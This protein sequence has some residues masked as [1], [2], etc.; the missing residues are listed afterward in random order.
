M[1]IEWFSK[2]TFIFRFLTQIETNTPY[3]NPLVT[4]GLSHP[5]HFDE[6]NFIFRGTPPSPPRV[7]FFHFFFSYFDENHVS[8]QKITRLD[9]TICGA[10]LWA[11]LSAYT[12]GAN[13]LKIS[14]ERYYNVYLWRTQTNTTASMRTHTNALKRTFTN[15]NE[16]CWSAYS[17]VN[18]SWRGIF[19]T[20]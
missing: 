1:W 14:D 17:S 9:A 11:F 16:L 15:E 5:Y 13:C 19:V 2:R 20:V 6:S 12:R 10:Q 3:I 4:N 18:A 8:K 7:I